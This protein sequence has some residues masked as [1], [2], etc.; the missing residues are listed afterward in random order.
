MRIFRWAILFLLAGATAV[1]LGTAIYAYHLITRPQPT[2]YNQPGD[3]SPATSVIDLVMEEGGLAL[4]SAARLLTNDW[5]R[6][7]PA[8]ETIRFSRVSSSAPY[9][10]PG[11]NPTI[12]DQM[13]DLPGPVTGSN[14][15]PG[16]STLL[17]GKASTPCPAPTMS[18]RLVWS[19]PWPTVP[20]PAT[21]CLCPEVADPPL[22]ASAP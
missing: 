3:V 2:T 7:E 14:R 4:V 6:S 12:T 20:N 10:L 16:S 17:S 8:T 9:L 13:N 11:Y 22:L 1:F 5:R 19:R 15:P 21:V 18:R